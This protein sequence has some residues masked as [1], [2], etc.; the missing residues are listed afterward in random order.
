MKYYALWHHCHFFGTRGACAISENLNTLIPL[1]LENIKNPESQWHNYK[2][3][4]SELKVE[5]I[6]CYTYNAETKSIEPYND[7]HEAEDHEF[8]AF[9]SLCNED[10][11][12]TF[13]DDIVLHR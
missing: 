2:H 9:N 1:H 13:Y 11:G 6:E 10:M 8:Y 12:L 3:N 4:V 5:P 7:S